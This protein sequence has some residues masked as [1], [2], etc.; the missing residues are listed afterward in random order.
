MC[1]QVDSDAPMSAVR[2]EVAS[3]LNTMGVPEGALRDSYLLHG[4]RV[5]ADD[6]VC[7][8]LGPDATLS[9]AARLRGGASTK[10]PGEPEQED[11]K[12][13]AGTV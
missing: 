6:A 9:L 11:Q 8:S 1:L 7:S 4:G 13:G 12:V 5:V 2:L 3:R 10:R